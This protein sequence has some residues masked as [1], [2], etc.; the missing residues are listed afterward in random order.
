MLILF[1][2]LEAVKKN[3]KQSSTFVAYQHIVKVHYGL[4]KDTASVQN[5]SNW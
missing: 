1:L 4:W 3:I 5:W 2:G